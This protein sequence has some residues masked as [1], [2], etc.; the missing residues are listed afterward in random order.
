MLTGGDV[1][2]D[3]PK[4]YGFLQQNNEASIFIP[5]CNCNDKCEGEEFRRVYFSTQGFPKMVNGTS[6]FSPPPWQE[7]IQRINNNFPT[8][9]SLLEIKNMSV[10]Y[11]VFE[12]DIYVKYYKK[13]VLNTLLKNKNIKLIKVFDNTY[14][15]EL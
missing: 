1:D 4:V 5:I 8:E 3:F 7:K 11:I 9:S 14:V 15:F 2:V 12:K 6:G 13:D 10:K